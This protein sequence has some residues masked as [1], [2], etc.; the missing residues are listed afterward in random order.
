VFAEQGL[1]EGGKLKDDFRVTSWGRWFRKLWIDELPMLYNWL[2][3]DLKIVGVRPLSRHYLSLYD[4]D[5]RQMR[6]QT[7]PGLIPPFYVDLPKTFEE[8]CESEKKYLQAFLKNPIKTDIYYGIVALY[9][10]FVKK[11]RSN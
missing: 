1:E 10:I 7:K 11:A 2:K 3:G 9:N 6:L 5:L 8:I 4:K